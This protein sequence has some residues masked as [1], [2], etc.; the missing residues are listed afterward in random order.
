ME[1]LSDLA[2]AY[3]GHLDEM[4]FY[5]A[6]IAQT[7][8]LKGKG[9]STIGSNDYLSNYLSGF[10]SCW[11]KDALF[12]QMEFSQIETND[13]TPTTVP[14][15]PG[16]IPFGCLPTSATGAP[17]RKRLKS[18]RKQGNLINSK[19]LKAAC[20]F[21][22]LPG[23]TVAKCDQLKQFVGKA[24]EILVDNKKDFAWSL[25]NEA[26]ARQYQVDPNNDDLIWQNGGIAKWHA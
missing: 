7:R 17:Q 26:A 22:C 23:H 5:G 6:L 2:K 12:S 19:K 21:C 4:E 20:S 15:A 9:D 11:S 18:R 25:V 24:T 16:L 10:M 14:L 3:E 13:A 8:L 1:L